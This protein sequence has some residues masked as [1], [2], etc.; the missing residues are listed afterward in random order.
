MYI[1]IGFSTNFCEIIF[2]LL[3]HFLNS[4]FFL[5]VFC[6]YLHFP[7]CTPGFYG[8]GCKL[9]CNCPTD[10]LCDH[11]TGGCKHPCPPGFHGE[12][13]HLCRYS[14][15]VSLGGML[16][17]GKLTQETHVQIEKLQIKGIS[18]VDASWRFPAE[19][20]PM[21]GTW[22]WQCHFACKGQ[23]R[24]LRLKLLKVTFH[25]DNCSSF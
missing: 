7:E 14:L 10:V 19:A 1:I 12:K 16:W 9:R 17:V 20:K 23:G 8:A 25:P 4:S 18:V 24:R 21:F 22:W 6:T 11:E 13:C 5:Y 3:F 15:H 2:W